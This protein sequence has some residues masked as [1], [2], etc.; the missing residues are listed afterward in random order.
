MRKSIL[1]G[2]L[3][4]GLLLCSG[5]ASY[6]AA[7]LSALSPQFVKESEEVPGISIG[8]KSF[9]AEDCVTYLDRD[10]IKKGYQPIE[11]TFYNQTDKSYFFSSDKMSIPCTPPQKVADKVHTSTAGRVVGYTVGA[12]LIPTLIIPAVVDGICS[13]K[14]NKRLD[15]DYQTKSAE[16][17]AIPPYSYK[18]TLL[19]VAHGDFSPNFQV[20]LLEQDTQVLKTLNVTASR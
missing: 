3:S 6:R 4:A 16:Y 8:C 17:F 14:A 10:V 18:E 11:L 13:Y 2:V 9:S 19:F 7:S 20:S 15:K 12:V 1:V 5:C